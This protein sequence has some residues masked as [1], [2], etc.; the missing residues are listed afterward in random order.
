MYRIIKIALKIF[1]R[2][3]LIKLS[4]LIHK[5]VAFF[6][7]GSN[8]HCP[9]CGGSFKKFLPYGYVNKRENALCP[10]C[11]SLERHRALWLYLKDNTGFF[12]NEANVLHIAPEQC[13]IKR[14]RNNK[15]FKYT[16][17]DIES[18]LA[19]VKMDICKNPFPDNSFDIIICNHVLEHVDNDS[20]AMQEFY[21]VLKPGGMG[22]F[23]VPIKIDSE[24]TDED[25]SIVDPKEREKRFGQYDHVRYY[26]MDYFARLNFAGFEIDEKAKQFVENMRDEDLMRYG[27]IKDDLL[28]IVKK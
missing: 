16:T 4:L 12:S 10:G 6:M 21:R 24:K 20:L 2:P 17:A 3:L 23:Q 27:I 7:R 13:F 1:P 19:D 5:V 9:V 18:P 28:P 22:I 14:F 26:G 25:S 8:V 11:L 15:N